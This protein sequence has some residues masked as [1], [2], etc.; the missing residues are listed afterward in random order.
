MDVSNVVCLAFACKQPARGDSSPLGAGYPR[1]GGGRGCRSWSGV[2]LA[3]GIATHLAAHPLLASPRGE[4]LLRPDECPG[5]V[6]LPTFESPIAQSGG[7]S[8]SPGRL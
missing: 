7:I 2:R 6:A 5:N 4:E 1:A 8:S 3:T